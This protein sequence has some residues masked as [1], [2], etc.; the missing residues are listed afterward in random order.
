MAPDE[1][2]APVS[3]AET[4]GRAIGMT[5]AEFASLMEGREA[6]RTEGAQ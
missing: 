2:P 3:R 5:Q 1:T 4:Y 6:A